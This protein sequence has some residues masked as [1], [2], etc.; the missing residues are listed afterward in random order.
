MNL[1]SLIYI[2][3][4]KNFKVKVSH[5]ALPHTFT[6]VSVLLYSIPP[7]TP[8]VTEQNKESNI[9]LFYILIENILGTNIKSKINIQMNFKVKVSHTVHN[10]CLKYIFGGLKQ[11]ESI[12]TE[13]PTMT[14]IP[15]LMEA[16]SPVPH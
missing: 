15:A 3:I 8:R 6:S 12:I 9:S 7:P 5:T 2:K 4:Q 11:A 16:A 10:S 14:F 1:F 13:N